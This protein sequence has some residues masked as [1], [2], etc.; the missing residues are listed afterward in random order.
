[1]SS[2]NYSHI[3]T[4]LKEAI[5]KE[6]FVRASERTIVSRS[7]NA[8]R[9][10]GWSFDF[11]S[12]TMRADM[13]DKIASLFWNQYKEILPQVGGQETASIP[14][15]SAIILQG[16]Q[17]IDQKMNGFFIRKSRKKD[18]LMQMIEGVVDKNRKIV[19][20]DDIMNSGKTFVRQI[21]VLEELGYSVDTVWS[22]LRYRDLDFYKYFHDKG[23]RVVSLF[24]LDDFTDTLGVTNIEY[25]H[26][27]K[28]T[29][30]YTVLWKFASD[31]P[32][33]FYVVPKCDPAIDDK[34]IYTGSDSGVFWALNQSDGSTAWSYKVG[35]HPKG[36]GIFSSPSLYNDTVYFGA[37]DGNVY[38]LDTNT[39]DKKWVSFEADWVGSSPTI[40]QNLNLLFVGLEFGLIKKRGGIVA[41]DV[42]TGA[43]VW[44]YTMSMY[45]HSSPLYIKET[46]QVII[47]SNDGT[48]YLFNAKNGDLIW[49]FETGT[50]DEREM[51]IGFSNCD[52]KESFA[53][54]KKRD[55]IIFGNILGM[56]YIL[57]R[58][59]GE[60][61]ATFQAN[62]GFYSTP[63]VYDNK[64]YA[65]S[66]DKHVYC[67]D[68]DTLKEKWRWYGG[69]RIFSSPTEIEGSIFIGSNT[70]RLT[71]L[72]PETGEERSFAIFP[73]R[74]TNK[75]AYNPKTKRFF[76]PTFA[77][78]I[79]C[80]EKK[81]T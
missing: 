2:Q 52:I 42:R 10:S 5:E 31:D 81:E 33:Y 73:E 14:I 18:N 53:Y 30:P 22:I 77:N 7:T 63:F 46:Q 37:Y 74:I 75:V 65:S 67:V 76:V 72:D 12:I 35:L 27:S 44:S 23:I 3:Y 4:Q 60:R 15:I 29:I 34:K 8:I 41:L 43:K 80:L 13:L 45:T 66:A 16:H 51:V 55:Y 32:S 71:E 28:L 24:S 20:V 48:A 61:V 70:G 11:R 1:M 64:V 59:T 56:L 9:E 21:E 25:R 36:K 54:D 38:A 49:K 57:N 19:L 50:I 39:G 79:Y 17:N 58:K 78:E 40:A 26:A 62:F 68:L 69:A 6:A 47:G